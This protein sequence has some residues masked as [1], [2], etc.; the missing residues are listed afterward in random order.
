[1]AQN[2]E[3][4]RNCLNVFFEVVLSITICQLRGGGGKEEKG[5]VFKTCK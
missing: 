2:L 4:R 3:N 5:V 1:M